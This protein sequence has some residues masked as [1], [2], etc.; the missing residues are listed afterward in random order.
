MSPQYAV[1]TNVTVARS[2]G[3][4]EHLLVRYGAD[5][6]MSGYDSHR[7]AIEFRMQGRRARLVLPLPAQ[8]EFAQTANGHRRSSSAAAAAWEQATRSRWRTLVLVLKAKLEAIEAGI[9]SFD[10][11]FGLNVV[12]PDGR[13]LGEIVVP[14]IEQAYEQGLMPAGLPGLPPKEG[15]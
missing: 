11:E 13:T 15:A 12:A 8:E 1:G 14:Q 4:I 2:R 10:Q 6:F 5:Q 3:E 9:V 7:A